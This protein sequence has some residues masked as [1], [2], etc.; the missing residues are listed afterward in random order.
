[1]KTAFVRTKKYKHKSAWIFYCTNPR[2]FYRFHVDKVQRNSNTYICP[3]CNE[4]FQL[5]W[6]REYNYDI[7]DIVYFYNQSVPSCG[8]VIRKYPNAA[9]HIVSPSFSGKGFRVVLLK[10]SF[11][12][13]NTVGFDA[14]ITHVESTP[15]NAILRSVTS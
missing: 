6:V 10:K 8:R 7:N 13:L 4:K 1:M 9:K 2:C 5:E 3:H 11:Q 12:H 14:H 15:L